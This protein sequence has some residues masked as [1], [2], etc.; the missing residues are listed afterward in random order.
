[1]GALHSGHAALLE[2]ARRRADVVVCS[3]F[4]NPKQFNNAADLAAYPLTLEADLEV[5]RRA[6]VDYV[7]A[8][9]GAEMYPGSFDTGLVAGRLAQG[10]EGASRPGHFDG[11]LTVVMLLL[12]V[13]QPH[14]AVFGEKDYQQL[15]LVRRMVQDLRLPIEIVAM[16]VLREVDGLALSS[17][18]ARLSAKGRQTALAL[19]RALVAGQDVLQLGNT[20]ADDIVAAASA[21]LEGTPGVRPSYVAVRDA[22]TLGE[23]DDVTKAARL[24]LAAEVDGIRLLDNGPL[25]PG[26][27]WRP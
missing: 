23:V 15:L 20:R 14:F 5:C 27:S 1:M 12:S 21:V 8:P 26:V 3:I 22:L 19:S 11:M 9:N 24:L 16:P 17:R 4:V 2:E 18:N 25:F 7:F 13:V 6:G 10:L